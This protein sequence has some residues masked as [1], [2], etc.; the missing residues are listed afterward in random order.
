MRRVW[1]LSRERGSLYYVLVV[2]P[3]PVVAY[4]YYVVGLLRSRLRLVLRSTLKHGK[5]VKFDG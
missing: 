1:T 4:S 2:G 5:V 3:L